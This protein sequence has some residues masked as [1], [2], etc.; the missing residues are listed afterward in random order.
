MSLIH[1]H[2]KMRKTVV[3]L[4]YPIYLKT[5]KV[6]RRKLFALYETMI[7]NQ[8]EIREFSV[9]HNLLCWIVIVA[10]KK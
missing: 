10:D 9:N 5:E 4:P 2:Q 7:T 3:V 8:R 1:G 6:L